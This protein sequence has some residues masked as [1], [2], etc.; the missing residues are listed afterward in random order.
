MSLAEAL[1]TL[2]RASGLSGER[3]ADR[4]GIS[5]S[6]ISKIETGRFIPSI[7]DVDR[8]VHALDVDQSY[9][10]ELLD[11]AR[12][13][14]AEHRSQRDSRRRGWDVVQRE[15]AAI[16]RASSEIRHL[17]PLMITGL[18]QTEQY[19]TQAVTEPFDTN[20]SG[21]MLREIVRNKLA[22]QQILGAPGKHFTFLLTEAALRWRLLPAPAMAEQLDKI[23]SA[24]EMDGVSVEVLPLSTTVPDCPLEVC[25]LYDD[26]LAEIE[27]S[28]GSL[29][30]R[31]PQDIAHHRALFDFFS[32][33]ALKHSEARQFIRRIADEFRQ[34]AG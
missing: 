14:T 25:V 30:L 32:S 21:Q 9:A 3:L 7:A 2:R 4:T 26:R 11:L 28:S 18:L 29:V 12:A 27:T 17:L 6:K 5:Q 20:E 8:I 16:E 23:V 34:E 13:A 22:R 24:S 19:A 15:I 33:Y 1:R 31:D 10:A